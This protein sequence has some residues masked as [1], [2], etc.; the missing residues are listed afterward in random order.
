MQYLVFSN[1]HCFKNLGLD[2]YNARTVIG[3]L[4]YLSNSNKTMDDTLNS[5]T[6][7]TGTETTTHESNEKKL[8]KAILCTIHQPTSEI[9]QCFS[10]IILLYQGR[11]VFQGQPQDAIVYFSKLGFDLPRGFNPADFYLKI[12]SNTPPDDESKNQSF[13]QRP[14]EILRKSNHYERPCIKQDASFNA[15]DYKM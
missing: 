10:H 2:S 3:A 1:V 8:A 9:F 7:G 12:L 13:F 11:C 15:N 4:K 14:I 6:I 5:F